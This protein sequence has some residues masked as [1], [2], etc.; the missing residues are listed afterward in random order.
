MHQKLLIKFFPGDGWQ[1][2]FNF[3]LKA[4]FFFRPFLL[5]ENLYNLK[6]FSNIFKDIFCFALFN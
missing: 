3:C 1:N 5:T 4:D 2:V 6:F